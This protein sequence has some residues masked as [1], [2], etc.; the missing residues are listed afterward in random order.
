MSMKNDGDTLLCIACKNGHGLSVVKFLYT[1]CTSVIY[2]KDD[3][4]DTPLGA[5]C[6]WG[7]AFSVMKYLYNVHPEAMYVRNNDGNTPSGVALDEFASG[8]RVQNQLLFFV[9][10]AQQKLPGGHGQLPVHRAILNEEIP[11]GTIKLLMSAKI[12]SLRH[13]D[14]HG[15]TPLHIACGGG[16]CDVVTWILERAGAALSVQSDEGKTPMQMLLY[17]AECD[18]GNIEYVQAVYALLRADPEAVVSLGT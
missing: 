11:F 10:A 7:H 6:R 12:E 15:N 8:N 9:E 16:K 1:A 3:D 4:G 13:A 5:L 17:H 2:M 14:F 18:R